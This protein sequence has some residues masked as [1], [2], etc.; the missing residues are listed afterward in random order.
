MYW[1]TILKIS[2]ISRLEDAEEAVAVAARND[3][4]EVEDGH[5]VCLTDKGRRLD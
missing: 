5:S 3:W 4:L 1:R 2:K